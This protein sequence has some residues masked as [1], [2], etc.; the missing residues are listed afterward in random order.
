MYP[1]SLEAVLGAEVALLGY[2]LAVGAL[3]RAS[4]VLAVLARALARGVH[5]HYVAQSWGRC[6]ERPQS[7][8]VQ[9]YCVCTAPSETKSVAFRTR[10]KETGRNAG[11]FVVRSAEFTPEA[12]GSE[13]RNW[14]RPMSN[15]HHQRLARASKY[16]PVPKPT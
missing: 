5:G 1:V 15:T 4:L 11:G 3:Q 12:S 7:D 6:A 2:F 8:D 16:L 13:G 9:D 10:R 14:P